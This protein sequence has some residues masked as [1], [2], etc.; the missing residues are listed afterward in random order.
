MVYCMNRMTEVRTFGAREKFKKKTQKELFSEKFKE[1]FVF[2]FEF[3]KFLCY[4]AV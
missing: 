2:F 3:G 4:F 1:I